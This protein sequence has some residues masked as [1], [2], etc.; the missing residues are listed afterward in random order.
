MHEASVS[1]SRCPTCRRGCGWA[2]IPDWTGYEYTH[3]QGQQA[4]HPQPAVR[5]HGTH[6]PTPAPCSIVKSGKWWTRVGLANM[7]TARAHAGQQGRRRFI[8][9]VDYSKRRIPG[10]RPSPG[11]TASCRQLCRRRQLPGR[12]RPGRRRR[13]NPIL[14]ETAALLTPARTPWPSTCWNLTPTS[15]AATGRC[16]ARSSYGQQKKAGHRQQRR[17]AARRALV[18]AVGPPRRYK[19][20]PRFETVLRA[21]PTPVQQEKR[22][23]P[24]WATASDDDINGI[25]RGY[26]L[27]EDGSYTYRQ[28][29]QRAPAATAGRCRWA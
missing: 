20:T 1:R 18:G 16:S 14:V 13:A 19:I 4:H 27:A 28:G 22:R 12:Q 24:C 17:R 5:H 21:G 9:R 6:R 15:C 11:C 29:R 8:Y 26:V 7:N 3:A 2:R 23:R 10:L 25:G